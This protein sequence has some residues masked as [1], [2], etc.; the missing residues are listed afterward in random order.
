MGGADI[1][2]RVATTSVAESKPTF[3][4]FW[5]NRR[6]LGF[7]ALIY[8]LMINSGFEANTLGN[9]L[10]IG[11]FVDRFG[12]EVGGQKV[13]SARDQQILNGGMTVGLF[14]AAYATGFLGDWFGRKKVILTGC[15][16]T[17]AGILGQY[18]STTILQLFG[19]KLLS[20]FG[21]GLG[22][23]LA[24][25]FVAE[26]APVKLRGVSLALVN[27]MIVLGQW[28]NSVAVQAASY[29]TDDSAWRVPIIAQIVFP[30]ILTVAIPFIAES[31]SWLLIQNRPE[32]AAKSLR[33]FNGPG[34]DIDGA[35]TVL[36]ATID[37]ER[38]METSSGTW[39]EC[40]RGSNGRRTLIICMV[41][42]AQSTIGVN[43][44]VSYFTYFFSLAGVGNAL[45]IAQASY[46]IQFLG[47][48]IS[49]PLVDRLGRR[50]LFV[51]GSIIMTALLLV[52]G[53]VSLIPGTAGAKAMVGLMA[54]WGFLV[55]AE[56]SKWNAALS[57]TLDQ[58]QGTVGS[59]AYAI[60]GE[61]PAP[62]LR[63]K[64]Y[65]INAM[66]YWCVNTVFLQAIPY[67]INPDQGNLG[68]KVG[69]VFFG[70]S[71]P[72]CIFQ[73]FN[74]PEMKGR[75]YA[76]LQEMFDRKLP[77]RQFKDYVC[78][79]TIDGVELKSDVE[80]AQA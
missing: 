28:L 73:Y 67:M 2:I 50:P 16:I 40:F 74:L 31:P 57:L 7:C 65:S 53:G 23:T 68:G 42:I 18:Y 10:A 6:I 79:Q 78:Q 41:Y 35:L 27:T 13:V 51:G 52:I 54:V 36:K 30:A 70:L 44:V 49:W 17:I 4:D 14:L 59:V 34:F 66:Q 39:A 45:G 38:E 3:R 20:S 15:V 64:T 22:H 62:T 29:R 58:Y 75:N 77:A 33:F 25:V 60:G 47:N 72:M 1:T 8:I 69:F 26:P 61:T 46:A 80:H 9:L 32:D 71:L 48:I 55:R 5:E 43:F 37:E 11:P 19:T 63:Q 21:F 12:V 76:E 56:L 24:P